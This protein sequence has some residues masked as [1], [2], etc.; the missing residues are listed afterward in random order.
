MWV[1]AIIFVR[2]K[3]GLLKIACTQS[4]DEK[5][6]W[7]TS[8]FTFTRKVN[9]LPCLAFSTDIFLSMNF[10]VRYLRRLPE[11]CHTN[12]E[13]KLNKLYNSISSFTFY[14]KESF[15]T[16]WKRV[17]KMEKKFFPRFSL[18]C[19]YLSERSDG[20]ALLLCVISLMT[21]HMGI[22]LLFAWLCAHTIAYHYYHWHDHF[23]FSIK[24]CF[25]WNSTEYKFV[26]FLWKC[27]SGFSHLVCPLK[28]KKHFVFLA[29]KRNTLSCSSPGFHNPVFVWKWSC[30]R[31]FHCDHHQPPPATLP[32][33]PKIVVLY[34]DQALEMSIV[35]SF[36]L[37]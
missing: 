33:Q 25:P 35:R 10:Y 1:W 30:F 18:F 20:N 32:P 26:H 7:I 11:D 17:E 34:I 8:H 36:F 2:E 5:Y 14:C 12:L 16:H 21:M 4:V 27:S 13:T 24:L 31:L 37:T 29:T 9:P 19:A 15:T 3:I 23:V 6:T 22:P 28:C